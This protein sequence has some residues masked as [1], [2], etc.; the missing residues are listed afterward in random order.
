MTSSCGSHNHIFFSHPGVTII[1][2]SILFCK[3]FHL[4][5]QALITHC[6]ASTFFMFVFLSSLFPFFDITWYISFIFYYQFQI[7]N[8]FKILLWTAYSLWQHVLNKQL[9][10]HFSYCN[11]F[12]RFKLKS[13]TLFYI[14][15]YTPTFSIYTSFLPSFWLTISLFSP[16]SGFKLTIYVFFF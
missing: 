5:I 9:V 16:L 6:L 1:L 12:F 11:D 8:I 10:V 14:S 4:N 3:F 2:T 15:I 13:T 7:L